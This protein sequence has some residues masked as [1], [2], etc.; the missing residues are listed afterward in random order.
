MMTS[1][2]LPDRRLLSVLLYPKVTFPDFIT[3]ASLELME[4]A[5]FLVFYTEVREGLWSLERRIGGPLVPSLR[6]SE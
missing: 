1:L 2:A 5:V 6:V 4:S 3:K